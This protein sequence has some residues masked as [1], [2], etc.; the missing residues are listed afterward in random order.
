[1]LQ[2]VMFGNSADLLCGTSL[3]V[4]EQSSKPRTTYQRSLSM[5]RGRAR[6]DQ[7]I[8]Y[9]LAVTP[10]RYFAVGP[11]GAQTTPPRPA[12]AASGPLPR[13]APS[14]PESSAARIPSNRR[15]CLRP[16]AAVGDR[17]RARGPR[18]PVIRAA[19]R[20]CHADASPGAARWW[21]KG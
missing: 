3:I 13:R 14:S 10:E 21:T 19:S 12:C 17:G 15:A 4:F 11:H 6:Q 1:M 2:R 16:V 8:A 5:R 7:H 9:T 20:Q 18:P